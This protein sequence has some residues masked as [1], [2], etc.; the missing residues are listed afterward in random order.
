MRPPRRGGRV[1]NTN[2]L[3]TREANNLVSAP[4]DEHTVVCSR[5]TP[6]SETRHCVRRRLA[7]A[8]RLSG[9][10]LL[11]DVMAQFRLKFS[12]RQYLRHRKSFRSCRKCVRRGFTSQ[13]MS[14]RHSKSANRIPRSQ[15]RV[16]LSSFDFATAPFT[17]ATEIS[18]RWPCLFSAAADSRV[19]PQ[20]LQRSVPT[21]GTAAIPN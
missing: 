8:T 21:N 9:L 15:P 10:C 7:T 2:R 6:K 19:V 16:E 13:E 1:K 12:K 18:N 4:S 17:M 5:R 11:Q 20:L 3:A 14:R